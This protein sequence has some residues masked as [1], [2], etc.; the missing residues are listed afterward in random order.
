MDDTI[1]AEAVLNADRRITMPGGFKLIIKV[2][3]SIPQVQIDETLKQKMKLAMVK[4]FNGTTNALDLTKFHSDPDLAD[5][6]CALFRPTVMLAAFDI[7]AENIPNLEALNLND[8]KIQLLDH[9]RNLSSKLPNLKI[10]HL[11]KNRVS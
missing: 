1:T 8:N 4:R 7:I 9:F 5:V 11:G 3:N 10:L 2:R 6:F